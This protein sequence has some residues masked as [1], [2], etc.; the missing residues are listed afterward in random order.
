M[1]ELAF[2]II[3]VVGKEKYMVIWNGSNEYKRSF[4]SCQIIQF[5]LQNIGSSKTI[6]TGRILLKKDI[7]N[8]T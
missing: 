8:K 5:W 2:F 3:G 4:Y 6:A 7:T 1:K